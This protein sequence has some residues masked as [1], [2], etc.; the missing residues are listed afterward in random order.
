[1]SYMMKEYAGGGSTVQEQYFGLKLCSARFVIECA[2]GR[3]KARFGCLR[4]AMDINID[5]LPHVIY[6]CFV[7]HNFCEVNNE[8]V[9]EERVQ[10]SI[11]YDRQFQPDTALCGNRRGINVNEAEGKKVRQ[12][13]TKYFDP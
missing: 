7:L 13:L 4:R 3:L 8:S 9:S 10:S 5:D 11:N 2:F 6:A 12:T 1:M